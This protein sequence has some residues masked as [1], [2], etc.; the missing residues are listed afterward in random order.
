M[1]VE[2][3]L[4]LTGHAFMVLCLTVRTM[5]VLYDT[6]TVVCATAV[7]DRSVCRWCR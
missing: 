1:F 5:N 6:Q 4:G 2:T 3:T 7:V